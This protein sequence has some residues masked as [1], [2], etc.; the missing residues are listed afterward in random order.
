[1]LKQKFGMPFEKILC[2]DYTLKV[3]FPEGADDIQVD[4]P[5]TVDQISSTTTK[6]YLDFVGRPTLIINKK[7]VLPDHN[8]I[9]QASYT[10][11]S[12]DLFYKPFYLFFGFTAL[13]AFLI[14]AAR[15]DFTGVSKEK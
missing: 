2:Q 1:V 11:E 6:S 12:Q 7:N 10:F 9:F 13:F 3:I 4:I 8:K 15:I 5:Y 14:L